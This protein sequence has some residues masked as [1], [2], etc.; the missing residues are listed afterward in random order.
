MF[1]LSSDEYFDIEDDDLGT[2]S[3]NLLFYSL[4]GATVA[5]ILAGYTYDIMGRRLTL[6]TGFFMASAMIAVVPFTSPKYGWL[7]FVRCVYAI[8]LAAP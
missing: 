6:F 7:V 3:S 2:A 1:L 5:T 4:P 8:F